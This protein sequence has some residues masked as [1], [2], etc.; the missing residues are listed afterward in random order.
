MMA[1][2]KGIQEDVMEDRRK[3]MRKQE[4]ENWGMMKVQGGRW[5]R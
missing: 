4:I 2:P 3:R 5:K 1:A